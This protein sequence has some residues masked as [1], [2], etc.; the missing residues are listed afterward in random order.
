MNAKIKA[1]TGNRAIFDDRT[2]CES[3]LEITGSGEYALYIAERVATDHDEVHVFSISNECRDYS[4]IHE[5][6]QKLTVAS[7][8]YISVVR[9]HRG[10]DGRLILR[11][12]DTQTPKDS[13][14]GQEVADW[15]LSDDRC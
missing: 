4:P 7:D 1:L 12:A 11:V 3:E 9:F 15:L 10:T 14:S 5:A 8:N 13:S 6:I 2:I